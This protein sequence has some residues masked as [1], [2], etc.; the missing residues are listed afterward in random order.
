[1]HH[2]MIALLMAVLISLGVP[3]FAEPSASQ[4]AIVK[5]YN[6]KTFPSAGLKLVK[7]YANGWIEYLGA[8]GNAV[9]ENKESQNYPPS[10]LHQSSAHTSINK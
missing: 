1:M 6:G 5:Q 7:D 4:L 8:D 3:V 2:W 10:I 9:Y